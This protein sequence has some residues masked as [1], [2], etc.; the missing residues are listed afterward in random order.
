M[1][2]TF[3]AVHRGVNQSAFFQTQALADAQTYLA[4]RIQTGMSHPSDQMA[5]VAYPQDH[6]HYFRSTNNTVESLYNQRSSIRLMVKLGYQMGYR[7]R[8]PLLGWLKIP[9]SISFC[10]VSA[11]IH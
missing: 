4:N 9:L 5:I 11:R 2:Q 1:K 8:L 10:F 3:I 7:F 6:I